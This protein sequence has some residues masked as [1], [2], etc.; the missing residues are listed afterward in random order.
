MQNAFLQ[1][2]RIYL[3]PLEI[4]DLSGDYQSW[5][6]DKE[7]CQFNS[8]HVFPY[9]RRDALKYISDSRRAKDAL[10]LAIVLKKN[11]MHIGN[12]A[13]QNIDHLNRKAELAILLGNKK[14]WNK[15]YSKEAAV[16]I[17]EHGFRALNLNR[18]YCGTFVKNLAM[19]KLAQY[20]N[21][22][23]EGLRRSDLYKDGSFVDVVEYGVLVSE[24][25]KK[26]TG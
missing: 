8:H 16:L 20:L 9:T 22:K 3:R 11:N 25:L 24:F 7:V 23:K 18:I 13:L 17:I 26:H 1:G 2:R 15:G 12:I 4:E 21:M 6:N 5:L 10:I 14:Y 19:Q